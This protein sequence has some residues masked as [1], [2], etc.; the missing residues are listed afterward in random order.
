MLSETN[1]TPRRVAVTGG[2][3]Y[4]GGRVATRLLADGWEVISLARRPTGLPG[5]HHERFEL[6]KRLDPASLAGVNALV[7]CAWDFSQR[8]WTDI[9]AVNVRGTQ[10]LFET[11]SS[12]GIERTVHISTV[13]ASGSPRSMYGR[14]KLLTEGFAREHGGTVVRPGLVYGQ[15]AGGM[16][17][18]LA[19]L[20]RL[21]P[22]IP[23]LV[24]ANR[25]LYL[26]HQDDLV[27]LVALLAGGEVG[28]TG[29]RPIIAAGPDSHSLRDVLGTIAAMEGRR[30]VFFRIPWQPIYVALRAMELARLP[31]PMRSDSALSI[32]TLDPNPFGSGIV[33]EGVSFRVFD[34]AA[35]AA[36][37]GGAA[38]P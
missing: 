3:G 27:E 22:A 35:L 18:M 19:A 13:S 16:V 6:G 33:P 11:A 5:V 20:V 15:G 17:G 8:T 10:A 38:A 4:L 1:R 21:L 34:A 36:D 23:V 31:P 26:A 25:P 29:G 37:P 24:G 2:S 12:C 7:H 32:A 28:E 30:R 9:E 14:A